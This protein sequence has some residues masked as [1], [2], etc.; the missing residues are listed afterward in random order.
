MALNAP[1]Q[2]GAVAQWGV[3]SKGSHKPGKLSKILDIELYP[4]RMS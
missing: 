2:A 4:V 1:V 3:V